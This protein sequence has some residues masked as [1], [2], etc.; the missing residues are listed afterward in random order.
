MV[1][2]GGFLNLGVRT[3]NGIEEI[4]AHLQQS[5]FTMRDLHKLG[6]ARQGLTGEVNARMRTCTGVL[7]SEY[8]L[9]SEVVFS[10]CLR[11]LE[12]MFF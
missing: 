5:C 11:S 1:G 3:S 10:Q 6:T 12:C 8:A 9:F 4:A 7:H 2:G